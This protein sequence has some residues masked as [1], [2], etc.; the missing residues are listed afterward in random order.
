VQCGA[1]IEVA[2]VADLGNNDDRIIV[3]SHLGD[4]L[5]PGNHVLGYDVRAVNMPG[6]ESNQ[7]DQRDHPDVI[8]VRKL[9]QK[10]KGK[11]QW[12][13]RRLDRT[14]EEG[15]EVVDDNDDLEQLKQ[16]LEMDP[17]LRKGVNMYKK[18]EP[19]KKSASASGT[20]AGGEQDD[21]DEEDDDEL[22]PEV[23]LAELLEGL[24]LADDAA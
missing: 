12:E 22:H 13:L 24:T 10:R 15:D 5:K 14:K 9:F 19:I 4:I 1:D 3:R 7:V 23:P 18:E 16:D 2:K 8:L 11:R 17:E 21:E 20:A 6:S